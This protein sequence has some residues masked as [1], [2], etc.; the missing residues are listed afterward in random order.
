MVHSFSLSREGR[1]PSILEWR[2]MPLPR[3]ARWTARALVV[4]V[5]LIALAATLAVVAAARRETGDRRSLA[6]STGRFVRAHDLELY[7]QETGPPDGQPVVLIHGTGAW[8]EIWR[9]TMTRLGERGYRAVAV[10]M[11]PF[12]FSERPASGDYTTATQGK[13]LAALVASLER[14]AVT[15]VGHS[16][17]ARATVEAAMLDP[18]RVT[19]LVL[20]DAA[21]GLHD[22]DGQPLP[23][24]EEGADRSPGM[25][26]FGGIRRP[27]VAGLITNPLMTRT[28]LRQLISRKEAATDAMVRMLQRPL[29]VAG[30]TT[31]AGEWLQ[32]FV[33][34]DLPQRSGRI[35]S[36]REL[37]LP[38]FVIWGATDTLTPL[39]QGKAIASLIPSARLRVLDATGHIPAI[40]SPAAFNSALIEFMTSLP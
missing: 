39:P 1:P 6:P 30:T 4:L 36:Y 27:V 25:L 13:R 16:F 19:A 29:G 10:D 3:F 38:T 21:L 33:D 32:W 15:F 2:R 9:E 24:V 12:G 23:D 17:G 34:P 8:S 35:A 26:A 14:S 37:N 28:L 18:R 31:A 7:V 20:V 5:I 22:A 40:E 11:P